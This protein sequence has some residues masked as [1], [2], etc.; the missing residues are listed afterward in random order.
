MKTSPAILIAMLLLGAAGI[1][2]DG[3]G[4][5]QTLEIEKATGA[6]GGFNLLWPGKAGRT[7]FLQASEDLR[8]WVYLESLYAGTPGTMTEWVNSNGPRMFLR[9]RFT[10]IPSLDPEG[11][12]FDGDGLS[13]ADELTMGTDPFQPDT[14]GDGIPDGSDTTP[15]EADTI[16][17]A[18]TQ[19]QVLS[20]L[21]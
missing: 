17:T 12:D 8:Q 20:P 6:A 5:A 13:N 21:Q 15:L 1:P 9:L 16:A 11:D 3:S 2:A 10:D 4:T 14:D 7:Y 19:P 18:S